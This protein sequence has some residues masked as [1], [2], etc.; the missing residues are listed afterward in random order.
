MK[1]TILLLTIL[2]SISAQAGR[3]TKYSVTGKSPDVNAFHH[4]L[5]ECNRATSD[6]QRKA[7]NK[8]Y[9]EGYSYFVR[10]TYKRCRGTLTGGKT[11][12]MEFFCE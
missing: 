5:I 1:K 7:N 4:D 6:A 2:A 12:K 8:C 11:R 10:A 3:R 9:E